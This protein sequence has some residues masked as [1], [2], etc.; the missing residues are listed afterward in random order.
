VFASE[1]TLVC[2]RHDESD[3]AHVSCACVLQMLLRCG[4]SIV[5]HQSSQ[6]RA[7]SRRSSPLASRYATGRLQLLRWKSESSVA[8]PFSA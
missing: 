1:C 5:R 7:Q 4:L 6:S 2:C 3:N 8:R